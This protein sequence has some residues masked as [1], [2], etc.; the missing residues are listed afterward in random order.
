MKQIFAHYYVFEG[1]DPKI[2]LFVDIFKKEDNYIVKSHLI[3]NS[4]SSYKPVWDYE[5]ITDEAQEMS[6]DEIIFQGLNPNASKG[7]KEQEL[8]ESLLYKVKN[9]AKNWL[10]I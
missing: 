2:E 5:E 1:T 7:K 9:K 4:I 10:N 8:A 6:F 3:D